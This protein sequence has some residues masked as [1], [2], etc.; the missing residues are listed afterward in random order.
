MVWD[1]Q[2]QSLHVRP[3]SDLQ[4]RGDSDRLWREALTGEPAGLDALVRDLVHRGQ[5]EKLDELRSQLSL[6][7]NAALNTVLRDSAPRLAPL[8]QTH[9]I[10]VQA[11]KGLVRHLMDVVWGKNGKIVDVSRQGVVGEHPTRENRTLALSA[12]IYNRDGRPAFSLVFGLA[13]PGQAWSG[14]TMYPV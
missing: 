3:V 1:A 5:L 8:F 14:A 11:L 2:R 13:R 7:G 6:T 9:P 4:E 12:A 10:V